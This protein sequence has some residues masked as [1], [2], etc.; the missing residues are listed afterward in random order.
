MEVIIFMGIDKLSLTT[1]EMPQRDY[2]KMFWDIREDKNRTNLYKYFCK[3]D[4]A[5]VM[6]R[7]HKFS[8]ETNMRIPYSKVDINPKYFDNFR[9]L[10]DYLMNIFAKEVDLNALGISRI[11]LTSDVENLPMDVVYSRLHVPGFYRDSLSIFKGTV[12]IGTNPKIRIYDKTKEIKARLKR[13]NG[14]KNWLDGKHTPVITEQEKRIIESGRQVTRFEIQLR[15]YKGNLKDFVNNPV[16]LV[17]NFDRV[18]L[19]NFE[20]D[21]KISAMVGGLQFLMTKINRKLRRDLDRFRAHELETLVK[22]NYI[23]SV[24]E[25]FEKEK[26]SPL[27]EIPF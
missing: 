10:C 13:I 12:Y 5:E 26:D 19:Y 4:Y 17:S 15:G 25:W 1:Y 18:R 20:D 27:E 21:E 9:F 3:M 23:D 22:N 16:S 8:D 24:K 11:D 6:W 7:P 2:L 14:S